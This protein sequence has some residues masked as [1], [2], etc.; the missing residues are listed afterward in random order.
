MA[1][2]SYQLVFPARVQR[3]RDASLALLEKSGR[4]RSDFETAMDLLAG[5]FDQG[6]EPGRRKAIASCSYL[7][8][9]LDI[10]VV[11][12]VDQKL[13]RLEVL[14]ISPSERLRKLVA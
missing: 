6:F 1:S 10:L 7:Y 2:A 11:L 12:H 5:D 3:S 8:N 14:A 4:P 13:R 9:L